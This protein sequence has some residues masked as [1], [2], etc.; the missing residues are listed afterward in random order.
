MEREFRALM[1]GSTAVTALAPAARIVWGVLG[2]GRALPALVLNLIYNRDGLTM[3]GPDGL[4]R[5]LV[6]VD[7]YGASYRDALALAEAVTGLLHGYRAGGFRLI[8]LERRR[9][10]NDPGAADRPHRIGLDFIINWRA[11]DAG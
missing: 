5:A 4:W 8:V 11:G 1:T 3:Q 2:Q 10:L 9:D 6:Q 7:C